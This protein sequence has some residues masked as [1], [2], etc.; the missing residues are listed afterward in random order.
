M[1]RRRRG[2]ARSGFTLVELVVA[3]LAASFL[4]IGLSS[5]MFI[6]LKAV[7]PSISPAAAVLDGQT[8]LT[9]MQAELQYAQAVTETAAAAI[10]V[11][12]PDRDD[13]DANAETIR[14]AWA[15]K[16]GD[17]LTRQYNGGTAEHVAADVHV[18][19]VQYYPS[20]AAIAYLTVR[21]QIGNDPRSSVETAIPLL[22]RP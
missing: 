17:P 12:V 13:P 19:N 5:A 21:L 1:T 11:T 10:T 9:N 20:S 3:M 22:N 6:A 18:F 15:A 7:D 2:T 4:V 14:Y 16:P 8:V